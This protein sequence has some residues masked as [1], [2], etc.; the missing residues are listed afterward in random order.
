M[1]AQLLNVESIEKN[2]LS[3]KNIKAKTSNDKD[4][5]SALLEGI[6]QQESSKKKS[7]KDLIDLL[8]KNKS[9]D[10]KPHSFLSIEIKELQNTKIKKDS[11]KESS[12]KEISKEDKPLE[13]SLNDL[14][15]I[16]N[17]SFS[18]QKDEKIIQKEISN[19]NIQP[20]K[21]DKKVLQEFK[22]AKN[23]Q[24]LLKTAQKNGIEIKSFSIEKSLFDKLQPN[25]K[26]IIDQSLKREETDTKIEPKQ[27][28][29]TIKTQEILNHKIKKTNIQSTKQNIINDPQTSSTPTLKSILNEKKETKKEIETKQLKNQK[30]VKRDKKASPFAII[31]NKEIKTQIK[32]VQKETKDNIIQNE[33]KIQTS[34]NEPKENKPQIHTIQTQTEKTSFDNSKN[35][36]VH[37]TFNNFAQKFQEAIESYKPPVTKVQISLNPKNLG[38][39]EVTLIHRGDNLQVSISPQNPQALNLFHQNQTEFRNAL[40]NIGFSSVDMNFSDSNQ[41]KNQQQNDQ[42]A[43][44]K[45]FEEEENENSIAT[46]NFTIPRYI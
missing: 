35:I 33:T 14:F 2:L 21:I 10:L 3:H 31:E 16:L 39:V 32:S 1:T 25:L 38:E 26:K 44:K 40:A 9:A 17:I 29:T 41:N 15:K 23:L 46:I 34:E 28:Q 19:L 13:I 18:N 24:E 27:D 42:K 6:L 37:K 30:E 20:N 36:N 22:E 11:I 8:I 7:K 45:D 4:L 43:Y 12:E 5:F